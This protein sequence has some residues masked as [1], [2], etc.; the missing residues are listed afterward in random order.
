MDAT[1]TRYVWDAQLQ[2]S[3]PQTVEVKKLV[4]EEVFTSDEIACILRAV[5][6]FDKPNKSK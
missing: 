4:S 3:V 6:G 2:R 1:I 5:L